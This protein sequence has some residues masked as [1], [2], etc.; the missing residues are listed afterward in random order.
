[1]NITTNQAEVILGTAVRDSIRLL[2]L[3][4]TGDTIKA[5]LETAAERVEIEGL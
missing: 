3:G 4:A 5:I 2:R 1:M